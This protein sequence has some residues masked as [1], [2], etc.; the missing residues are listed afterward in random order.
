MGGS[1][2][3]P[4]LSQSWQVMVPNLVETGL[5]LDWTGLDW[6]VGRRRS[7]EKQ[8]KVCDYGFIDSSCPFCFAESSLLLTLF[9]L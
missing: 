5:W 8:K 7:S 1:F 9:S 2:D 3:R 6:T 4:S